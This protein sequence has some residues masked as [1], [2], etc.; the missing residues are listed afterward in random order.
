MEL[1]EG[2]G[3]RMKE[4]RGVAIEGEGSGGKQEVG[5][6]KRMEGGTIKE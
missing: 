5:W 3:I 4:G 6:R 2:S 1:G